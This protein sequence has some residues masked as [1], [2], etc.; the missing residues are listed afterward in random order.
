MSIG[1]LRSLLKL[2][3]H[4]R[5]IKQFASPDKPFR[6]P[7]LETLETR[8]LPSV[9][10]AS[11]NAVEIIEAPVSSGT[12]GVGSV[13]GQLDNTG[14]QSESVQTQQGGKT[15]VELSSGVSIHA[16]VRLTPVSL[17]PAVG[18]GNTGDNEQAQDDT[19]PGS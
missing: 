9:F 10:A 18:T 6:R 1:P 11:L 17:Q 12:Q 16:V 5:R 19:S 8:S 4:R 2:V 15:I 14:G 7:F 13:A 3:S